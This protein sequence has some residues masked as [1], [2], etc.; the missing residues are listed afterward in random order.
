MSGWQMSTFRQYFDDIFDRFNQC[1]L[2]VQGDIALIGGIKSYKIYINGNIHR[3]GSR[4]VDIAPPNS[5]YTR[6][7]SGSHNII[8]R[9]FDH[10]QTCRLESNK[11]TV[12]LNDGDEVA[13]WMD[14][15]SEKLIILEKSRSRLKTLPHV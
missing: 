3:T 6:I 9:E 10:R 7:A 1:T 15:N 13:I 2:I 8:I 5:I 12:Q 14:I 11:I 4:F